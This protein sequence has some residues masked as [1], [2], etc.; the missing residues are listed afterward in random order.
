MALISLCNSPTAETTYPGT[1][2]KACQPKPAHLRFLALS[3]D[4]KPSLLDCMMETAGELPPLPPVSAEPPANPDPPAEPL[5]GPA[6]QPEAHNQ[7]ISRFWCIL[8]VLSFSY[9]FYHALRVFLQR[10]GYL[11]FLQVLLLPCLAYSTFHVSLGHN[12]GFSFASFCYCCSY[13]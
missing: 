5:A 12:F 1:L 2:V 7:L 4:A 9:Q 13:T 10:L 8:L 3:A 11:V 6:A